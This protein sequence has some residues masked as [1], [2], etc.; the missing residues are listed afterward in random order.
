VESVAIAQTALNG[1]A[2][3]TVQIDPS[4]KELRADLREMRWALDHAGDTLGVFSKTDEARSHAADCLRYALWVIVG[5][6]SP[7]VIG[8]EMM[9]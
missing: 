8:N 9:R 2:G 7:Q 4:C 6:G 5:P 1:N 3:T